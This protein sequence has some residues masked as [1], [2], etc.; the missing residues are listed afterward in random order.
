MT[1]AKYRLVELSPSGRV[2]G[3]THPAAKLTDHDV[4]L[5]RELWDGGLAAT[6]IAVKFEVSRQHVYRIVRGDNRAHIVA[7][8]RRCR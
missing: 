3:E 6:A 5:I 1:N 2:C 4:S 7:S 8:V